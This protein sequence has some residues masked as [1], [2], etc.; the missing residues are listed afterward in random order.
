MLKLF[1]KSAIRSLLNQKLYAGI[2]LL[3]LLIG[4][5]SF[6]SI[7][8]YVVDESSYDSFH[9]KKDQIYRLATSNNKG[10]VYG[11]VPFPWGFNM[12]NEIPEIESYTTFQ[13]TAPSI[14]LEN[15]VFSEDKILAVDSLF[16]KTFDFPVIEGDEAKLLKN[17]SGLVLSPQ[18]AQQYFGKDD[19]IGKSIELGMGGKYTRFVVEGIVESPRNSHIQFSMLIPHE[20]VRK[21][22]GNSSSYENWEANFLFSYVVLSSGTN[23]ENLNKKF[24]DFL[25]R[26]LDKK[27]EELDLLPKV[28]PLEDMYLKSNLIFDFEPR[29]DIQNSRILSAI[30]I[31]IFVISL[32]NMINI[33]SAQS[34]RRAKE[35]GLKKIL[36]TKRWNVILQFMGESFIIAFISGLLT[37]IILLLI[38]PIFNEFSGKAFASYDILSMQNLLSMLFFV[39]LVSMVCGLYP[40]L[41]L[42]SF[43]P[44][45]VLSSRSGGR[46]K[47]LLLRKVLVVIQFSLAVVLFISTGVIYKQVRFMQQKNLGFDKEQVLVIKNTRNIST[48]VQEM[49]LLKTELKKID[50]IQSI[51]ASSRYPGTEPWNMGYTIEGA[52]NESI[53]VSTF[54]VD[55][56]FLETFGVEVTNGRNFDYQI[57]SDST[58]FLINESA[59]KTFSDF[60]YS[61][62][63]NPL[64]K[65]LELSYFGVKGKVIGVFEDFHIGSL[66]KE[67]EPLVLH[68]MP[69][70]HTN[71]QVR[72]SL[73]NVSK[74]LG[75]IEEIWVRL[76]PNMPFN[77]S[78]INDE[79]HKYYK[80]DRKLGELLTVLVILSICIGML[81]LFGLASF[82]AFDKAKEVS[83]KKVIGA[84]EIRLIRQLSWVFLKLVII[85]NVI[86]LP[87]SY[88]LMAEWLKD[89]AYRID[90][91]YWVF[92]M[93]IGMTFLITL[94]TVV[95]HSIKAA[96][97]NPAEVLARE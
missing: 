83:I 57:Q 92:I 56:D 88:F 6:S 46:S 5:L 67:L 84:S 54:M 12:V 7:M 79:F 35:V 9:Q 4:M 37:I 22:A 8:I 90:I 36:G 87:I 11:V 21:N 29:G 23:F 95:Y 70:H 86:A 96:T 61:W 65:N 44:V 14:R 51:S 60:D 28:L 17:V 47:G 97:A 1:L 10:E 59:V 45:S 20:F 2:N 74:T 62:K 42:F 93:S 89:F 18:V 77:Y 41:L 73:T 69:R 78:F 72:I 13:S 40:A 31:G 66:K 33:T 64:Q 16:L 34:L 53:S 15:K 82:L 26:H 19:P 85:A 32:I 30:A 48:D 39:V 49:R 25:S 71:I 55:Q 27:I 63:A 80:S 52:E 38:L 24:E 75:E 3:G 81:G 68:I 76:Y 43:T 94:F 50:G 58:A 91:P